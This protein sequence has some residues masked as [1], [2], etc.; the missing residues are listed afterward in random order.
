MSAPMSDPD[1]RRLGTMLAPLRARWA[2]LADRERQA[3]L[4]AAA[5][6]GLFLLWVVALQP[7]IRTVREAPKRLDALDL[8][9]QTMQRLASEARE[10][11]AAP[12]VAP[13]Q[14]AAALRAASERLGDKGRLV[15]QGERAV[16][17]VTEI[18]ADDLRTWIAEARAAARARPVELKLTRGTQ[19]YSGTLVVAL[20]SPS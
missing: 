15:Q 20:G 10:L 13:A 18:G 6:L 4:L 1:Q 11:R 17:T 7:A 2:A 5:V 14:A 19:G 12:P 8:Q 9:L 16:L 3:A